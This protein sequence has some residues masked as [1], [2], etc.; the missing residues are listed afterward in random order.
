MKLVII[1]W[2]SLF[3]WGCD[4]M[5][6]NEHSGFAAGQDP[7]WS[8]EANGGSISHYTDGVE[9]T[10]RTFTIP[11]GKMDNIV[12][13]GTVVIHAVFGGGA[14]S[15]KDSTFKLI[16]GGQT[17]ATI[18]YTGSPLPTDQSHVMALVTFVSGSGWRAN[19]TVLQSS[20]VV[21][22]AFGIIALNPADDFV[23]AL[24]GQVISPDSPPVSSDSV[25]CSFLGYSFTGGN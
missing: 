17:I 2:C 10:L 7:V 20:G 8:G 12:A 18:Q 9:T 24:T 23:I 15:T 14:S 19:V 22:P 1:I 4:L 5:G 13:G 11:A 6:V 25:Y 3:L 21:L 16:T